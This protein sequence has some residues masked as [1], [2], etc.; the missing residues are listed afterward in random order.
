[1]TRMTVRSTTLAALLVTAA[2]SLHAGTPG[3]ADKAVTVSPEAALSDLTLANFF[4]EG[5]DQGWAKRPH[6]DGAPDMALLRAQTNFLESEF[7]T[8]FTYQD[9]ASSSKTKNVQFLNA[10]VAYGFNRRFMFEV[11]GNEQWNNLRNGGGVSGTGLGALARFQLVDTVNSSYALN[12]RVSTPDHGIGE[13]LTTLGVALAGW[14]DLTRFGLNRTGLYWHVQEETFAG[15]AAAGVRRND[16]T[17]DVTLAQT[18]TRP[19]VPVFGNFTTFLEAFAR[20]DLDGSHSGATSL[21]LTPGIRMTLGHGHVLMFGVDLPLS[22]P[23]TYNETWRITYIYN[24]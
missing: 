9:S 4:S 5:W 15:P 10:L 8:D 23:R 11:I 13:T 21:S 22:E 19:D 18:W 2:T 1:M 24:F 3:G 14:E 7:R 6:P 16:M 17:Y 12:L 20:T